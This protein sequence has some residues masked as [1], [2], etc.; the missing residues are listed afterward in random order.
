MSPRLTIMLGMLLLSGSAA[1]FKTKMCDHDETVEAIKKTYD[2]SLEF[3]KELLKKGINKKDSPEVGGFPFDV[4]GDAIGEWYQ[5]CVVKL[6]DCVPAEQVSLM[7]SQPMDPMTLVETD[8]NCKIEQIMGGLKWTRDCALNYGV[9]KGIIE[10]KN[11]LTMI[12]GPETMITG[13]KTMISG[14]EPVNVTVEV[15]GKI[16]TIVDECFLDKKIDCFSKRENKFLSEILRTAFGDLK[17][18]YAMDEVQKMIE[19]DMTTNMKD[20]VECALDS[21]SGSDSGSVSGSGSG[22]GS[23]KS[24]K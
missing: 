18:I 20:F 12:P 8:N 2:C 24:P 16:G 14:P 3:G 1:G 11:D 10:M 6:L 23:G 7:T 13:P 19:N 9:E 5:K 15:C 17:D 21:G 4:E 22:S